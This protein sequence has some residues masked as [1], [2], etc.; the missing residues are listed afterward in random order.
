MALRSEVPPR[1]R[2][3]APPSER[4]SAAEVC[5]TIWL[6]K[7]APRTAIPVAM[8]TWR[9]VLFAPEAMPLRWGCTTE[10]APE[11]RTGFTMPIPMPQATNPGSNTVHVE[12]GSVLPMS[13]SPPVTNIMP[14]PKTA[15]DSMRTVRRPAKNATTKT[16]SVRG[17]KRTPAANGP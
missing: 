13:S 8:P 6:W 9:K 1:R 4:A 5:V 15:R 11:A 7:T 17:R 16:S 10:T 14:T 12:V 3:A 2:T